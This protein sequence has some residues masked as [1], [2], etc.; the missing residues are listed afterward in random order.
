MNYR[1]YVTNH[2]KVEIIHKLGRLFIYLN[3]ADSTNIAKDNDIFYYLFCHL[4]K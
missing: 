2:L 4:F 3:R 1:S